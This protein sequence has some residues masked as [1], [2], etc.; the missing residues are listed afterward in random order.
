[1][2]VRAEGGEELRQAMTESFVE[3]QLFAHLQLHATG[4][5]NSCPVFWPTMEY[6]VIA[7]S[8]ALRNYQSMV[9]QKVGSFK[10]NDV[11]FFV[12]GATTDSL[13]YMVRQFLCDHRNLRLISLE[14]L[15]YAVSTR[16]GRKYPHRIIGIVNVKIRNLD[17][18]ERGSMKFQIIN[19]EKPDLVSTTES[20]ARH[21]M[22]GFDISVCRVAVTVSSEPDL[23]TLLTETDAEDIKLG[24]FTYE[25]KGLVNAETV[26]YRIEKY[27]GR[28]FELYRIIFPWFG[29]ITC[30]FVVAVEPDRDGEGAEEGI[31]K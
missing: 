13:A 5:Q 23:F 19:M 3:W 17:D 15:R 30:T 20:F 22:R 31:Q 6:V 1:M 29:A 12:C 11:D 10:P 9:L 18:S 14:K 27:A 4:K 21:V 8:Y 28:G 7:G 26:F 2:L 24:R 25:M 16:K